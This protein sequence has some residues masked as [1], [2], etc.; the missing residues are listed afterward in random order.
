MSAFYVLT[1]CLAAEGKMEDSRME[2]EGMGFSGGRMLHAEV[3]SDVWGNSEDASVARE[4]C[5]AG[6]RPERPQEV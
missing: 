2:G 1:M 5:Q 6:V 4:D 3:I